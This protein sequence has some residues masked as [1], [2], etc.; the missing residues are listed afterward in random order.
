MLI[1]YIGLSTFTLVNLKASGFLIRYFFFFNFKQNHLVTSFFKEKNSF[2]NILC[3]EK[4]KKKNMLI[5]CDSYIV[6][7]YD[8]NK[9]V[10]NVII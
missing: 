4:N 7:I 1:M 8:N 6:I 2:N 9:M 10:I 5:S 3:K